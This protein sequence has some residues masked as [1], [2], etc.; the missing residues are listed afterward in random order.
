MEEFFCRIFLGGICFG[1]IFGEGIFFEDF[2]GRNFFGGTFLEEFFWEDFFE[3][4]F[5]EDFFER[6]FWEELFE[7]GR[8][9]F[10]CQHLDFVSIKKEGEGKNL[11]PWKCD[12]SSSHLKKGVSRHFSRFYF[13]LSSYCIYFPTCVYQKSSVCVKLI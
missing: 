6:N 12:A 9:L 2:W 3:R 13:A 10:V 5:R 11:D 4:I 1:G 7:S 8:N